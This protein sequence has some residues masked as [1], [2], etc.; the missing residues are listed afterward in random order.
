MALGPLGPLTLPPHGIQHHYACLALLEIS[1]RNITVHDRR[2]T[3]TPLTTRYVQKTG[4]TIS[5]SLTVT[6]S[7]N[8]GGDVVAGSLSGTLGSGTVGADQVR[9]HSVTQQKLDSAI[10]IVPSGFS[11]LGNT[12]A[13]PL[14]MSILVPPLCQLTRNRHGSGYRRSQLKLA[15]GKSVLT[16]EE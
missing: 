14:A 8:V 2:Q 12:A 4:D 1:N 9:D 13:A 16:V 15:D 11:I 3:F 10:G 5:G 6:G 7:L